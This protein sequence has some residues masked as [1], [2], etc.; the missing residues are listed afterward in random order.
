MRSHHQHSTAYLATMLPPRQPGQRS[1]RSTTTTTIWH[2]HDVCLLRRSG[3]IRQG[4]V[5][6]TGHI[7]SH[8][9]AAHR[10]LRGLQACEPALYL[11]TGTHMRS[12]AADGAYEK[13]KKHMLL[14]YYL[15]QISRVLCH[16][17]SPV[18][19]SLSGAISQS[20]KRYRH[21]HYSSS[22]R[23]HKFTSQPCLPKKET[24]LIL[25]SP[26]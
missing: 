2:D 25:A 11:N 8:R 7:T 24:Y 22:P 20:N 12:K 23:V 9:I 26:A 5:P 17:F 16:L 10:R 13:R 15:Q 19:L 4:C 18:L 1:K 14:H 21:R 3:F 6:P